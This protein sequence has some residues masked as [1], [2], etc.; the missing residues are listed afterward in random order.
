MNKTLN[1]LLF[2]CCLW[3]TAS[4]QAQNLQ[5]ENTAIYIAI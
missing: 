2:F 3:A 1:F 4:L 5:K